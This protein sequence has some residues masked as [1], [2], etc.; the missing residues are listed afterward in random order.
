MKNS[1]TALHFVTDSRISTVDIIPKKW[2]TKVKD[3]EIE[4]TKYIGE[5][6]VVEEERRTVAQLKEIFAQDKRDRQYER[7]PL[8]IQEEDIVRRPITRTTDNESTRPPSTVDEDTSRLSTSTFEDSTIEDDIAKRQTSSPEQS[9]EEIMKSNLDADQRRDSELF[10]GVS[11]GLVRL[12][13]T[14]KVIPS[15]EGEH[16]HKTVNIRNNL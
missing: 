10:Q 9:S 11:E 15:T 1:H 12:E 4:E 6:K 13:T 3:D 2:P 7:Q 14:H 8:I 5:E 16:I